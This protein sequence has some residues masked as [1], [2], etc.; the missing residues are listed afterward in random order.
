MLRRLLRRSAPHN[1]GLDWVGPEVNKYFI[2]HIHHIFAIFVLT[3]KTTMKHPPTT[4][5]TTLS[6]PPSGRLFYGLLTPGTNAFGLTTELASS[7]T[8]KKIISQLAK[9]NK[10]AQRIDNQNPFVHVFARICAINL[11]FVNCPVTECTFLFVSTTYCNRTALFT[12]NYN[13]FIRQQPIN[14]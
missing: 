13:P 14:Q 8:Q 6:T 10:L 9:V 2:L 7:L 12:K 3:E 11:H 1:D 4:T 5:N